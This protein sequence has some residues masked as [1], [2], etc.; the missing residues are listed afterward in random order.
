MIRAQFAMAVRADEKW[1]ENAGR[2]L[3][4]RLRFTTAE[5]RWL[6]L[7]RILDQEVGLTLVK[8][9]ELADEALSHPADA[10]SVIVGLNEGASAGVSIDLPRY[11]STFAAALSAALGL[12]GPRRRGKPRSEIRGKKRLLQSAA[13][14][15][16]D[17]AL[18]R[19]GLAMSPRERLERLDE[20]VSFIRQ[21][22]SS[23]RP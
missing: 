7:V 9:A 22:R 2:I 12:G 6:G 16:V 11:H 10:R 4:R 15:G 23:N 5:A 19:A 21:M 1:V 20:N 14:Y 8:S 13:D 17:I 3:G 18:L